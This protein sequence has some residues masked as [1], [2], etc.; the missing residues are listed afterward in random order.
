MM[1]KFGGTWTEQKIQL[2]EGYA[3]AYLT[4][5]NKYPKFKLMYFDGFAGSGEI[6]ISK[7]ED[8]NSSLGLEFETPDIDCIQGAANRV[9]SINKPKSFDMYYFV[10]LD[11]KKAVALKKA[12]ENKTKAEVYVVTEDCNVKLK[13]LANFLKSKD[14]KS[15]KV[16]AFIDPFGMNLEWSSLEQLKGLS[17]D[18]WIL[19]P[20]GLGANRLLKK[21]KNIPKEWIKRLESFFGMTSLELLPTFYSEIQTQDLFGEEVITTTKKTKPV[22]KINSIY[23]Q[24]LK[25]VFEN[26]SNAY[27]IKNSSNSIMFHFFLASN[28]KTAIRIANDMIK[29]LNN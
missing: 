10:E 3:K 22:Q 20:T 16:L 23:V 24:K 9:I 4:I 18:M 12:L 21:D 27:V 5:M 1:N 6:K 15:Y 19:V 28:N 14:G 17:V 7:K 8:K 11:N 25:T 13:D 2:I 29:R 26:I